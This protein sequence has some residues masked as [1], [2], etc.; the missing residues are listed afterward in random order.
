MKMPLAMPSMPPNALGPDAFANILQAIG[1][2]EPHFIAW[3]TVLVEILGGLAA[4]LGAFVT[5]A[6]GEI[7]DTDLQQARLRCQNFVRMRLKIERIVSF[8]KI[9]WFDPA[10]YTC[11]RRSYLLYRYRRVWFKKYK[12]G[13]LGKSDT[14]KLS[15]G[16]VQRITGYGKEWAFM[17]L[18]EIAELSTAGEVCGLKH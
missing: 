12:I 18:D 10:F 4:T 2:P 16:L 5:L 6:S 1:V 7:E 3:S 14:A 13:T 15:K 17:K 9:L 11:N 8:H